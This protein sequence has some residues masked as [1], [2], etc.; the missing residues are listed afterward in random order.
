MPKLRRDKLYLGQRNKMQKKPWSIMILVRN[1]HGVQ[2]P[3]P[4][5]GLPKKEGMEFA[6]AL[7]ST[8]L[9]GF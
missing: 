9:L 3:Q 6:L 8:P 7:P 4:G 1:F 2:G 5:I